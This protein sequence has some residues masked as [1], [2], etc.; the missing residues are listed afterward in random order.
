MADLY[1]ELHADLYARSYNG[2]PS[3]TTKIKIL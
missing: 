3:I 2:Y 1:T